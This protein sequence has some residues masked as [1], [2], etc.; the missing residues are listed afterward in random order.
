MPANI[1]AALGNNRRMREVKNQLEAVKA[2]LARLR[3]ETVVI[4]INR[5]RNKFQRTQGVLTDLYPAIFTVTAEGKVM[6]FSYN[7]IL[8]RNV[9]FCR[10]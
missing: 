9:R 2:A 6:S 8:S 3:G 4:D 1:N 5:G 10:K 7:D